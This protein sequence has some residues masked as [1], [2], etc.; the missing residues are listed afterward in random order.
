MPSFYT[1]YAIARNTFLSLPSDVQNRLRP[2]LPLY[3]FGAQGAD[4]CF[5]YRAVRSFASN[6]QN[7]GS[8]LHRYGGRAVF[9]LMQT[10]SLRDSR[11][12]AYALGYV[13][14][15]AADC[16]FH[17]FVYAMAGK[18]HVQ[19]SR[20]EN[21]LDGYF[22]TL[23]CTIDP[24][25]QY[26]GKILSN[27]D[28]DD[29]FFLFAAIAAKTGFPPLVKRAF[30]RALSLFNSYMGIPSALFRQNKPL[31]NMLLNENKKTWFYPADPTISSTDGANDLF[32]R[33]VSTAQHLTNEFLFSVKHQTPLS[34]SLF[35]NNFLTGLPLA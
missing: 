7:F 8:Y 14:H 35:N 34:I 5:F 30:L 13:T 2:H 25:L 18:S 29:L 24:Y 22:K 12:L 21:A 6:R 15:Y 3:F 16:T 4:F 20:I 31:L 26:F 17:P 19:H 28:A 32:K 10:L 1:H 9:T 27:E 11:L 33:S 23:D